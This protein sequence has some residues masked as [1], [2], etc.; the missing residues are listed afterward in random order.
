V[1]D[2]D[3]DE[4]SNQHDTN[5]TDNPDGRLD[6]RIKVFQSNLRA[7]MFEARGLDKAE[8]S[9]QVKTFLQKRPPDAATFTREY[10]GFFAELDKDPDSD[11][12]PR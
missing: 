12:N 10:D 4:N 6:E 1:T 7:G 5:K 2:K 3:N 8:F 11:C 9:E